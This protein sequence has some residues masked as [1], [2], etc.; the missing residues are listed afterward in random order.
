MKKIL[1][2]ILILFII[3]GCSNKIS[4]NQEKFKKHIIKYFEYSC[5]DN[6]C[7]KSSENKNNII[8]FDDETYTIEINDLNEKEKIKAVY[9]YKDKIIK[10]YIEKT[11]YEKTYNFDPIFTDDG[12]YLCN[13]VLETNYCSRFKEY[14]IDM[15]KDFSNMLDSSNVKIKDIIKKK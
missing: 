9:N 4:N 13:N 6:I 3:S 11:V 14:L 10:A 1:L 2:L 5:K 15:K 8:D 7:T 12:I